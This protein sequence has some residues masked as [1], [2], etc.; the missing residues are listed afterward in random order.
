MKK[1]I[2]AGLTLA[3]SVS[4]AAA[5]RTEAAKEMRDKSLSKVSPAVK[6]EIERLGKVS[7]EELA[8]TLS[9]YSKNVLT[10][11]KANELV[12]VDE[13]REALRDTAE[14]MQR[15]SDVKMSADEKKLAG[16]ANEVAFKYFEDYATYAKTLKAGSVEAKVAQKLVT[17]SPSI[18]LYNES[19]M[20]GFSSLK[21]EIMNQMNKGV[22]FGAAIRA[23][24]E[25]VAP[26]AG[27][28]KGSEL[29]A[30]VEE[31]LK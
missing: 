26:K 1:M 14:V 21:E 31:C 16:T 6:T 9:T 27:L 24:A 18:L 20:A 22:E 19:S 8:K 7:K 17:L 11:A 25:V 15:L 28:K 29:L 5:N 30:K 12:K 10:V 4:F 23:A 13:V 2:I 3:A